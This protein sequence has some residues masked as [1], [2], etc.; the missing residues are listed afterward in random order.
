MCE[1]LNFE[2][3]MCV[4]V[5][6]VTLTSYLADV[7]DISD[8]A[9]GDIGGWFPPGDVQGVG[10]QRGGCEPLR[11]RWQIFNHGDGQ[12]SAGLVSTGT[13]LCNA[14]IDGFILCADTGQNQSATQKTGGGRLCCVRICDP[15]LL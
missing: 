2:F 11:G 5:C 12:T 8:D 1:F 7:Q 3:C 9:V 15:F 13:V 6:A 10:G 4:C 14:L